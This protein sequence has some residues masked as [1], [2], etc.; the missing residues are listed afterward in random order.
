MSVEFYRESPGK[1]DS[2]TLDRK[3]LSRWTGRKGM[4]LFG[5][6]REPLVP[7]QASVQSCELHIIIIIIIIIVIIIIVIIVSITI[8]IVMSNMLNILLLLSLLLHRCYII[9]NMLVLVLVSN[10]K[11]TDRHNDNDSNPPGQCSI[12]WLLTV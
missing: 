2:R 1:F 9:S 3:T 7:H 6:R 11:T 5:A 12:V 8:I 4:Y 10:L